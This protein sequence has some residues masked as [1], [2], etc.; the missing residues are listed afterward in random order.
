MKNERIKVAYEG[1]LATPMPKTTDADSFTREWK[2]RFDMLY[3]IFRIDPADPNAD[4]R[5][6]LRLARHH[7]PGLRFDL[8]PHAG[9]RPK[10]WDEQRLA[11]LAIAV[12]DLKK[13]QG[14][15]T[16]MEA[17]GWLISGKDADGW[18]RPPNYR[19]DQESW[20]RHLCNMASKGRKTFA[21]SIATKPSGLEKTLLEM[22]FPFDG[23]PMEPDENGSYLGAHLKPLI[24]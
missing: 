23:L 14:A 1:D 22:F 15:S 7:V 20:Q 9:G 21:Y 16:D 10:K 2:R 24:T 18:G 8:N 11:E 5:L 6:A 19:R 13:K 12:D 3:Q 17:C 4:R